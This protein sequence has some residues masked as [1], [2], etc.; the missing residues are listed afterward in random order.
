M[1]SLSSV[2]RNVFA[3]DLKNIGLAYLTV[4]ATGQPP[5]SA[6]D[7]GQDI[8]QQLLSIKDGTL[9]IFWGANPNLPEASNTVLGYVKD[10]PEKGGVVLMLD[11]SIRQNMTPEE[12]KAAPKAR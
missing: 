4:A 5:R 7:L 9:V 6:A 2:R 3:N 10:V 8:R 11:G 12:F 1:A